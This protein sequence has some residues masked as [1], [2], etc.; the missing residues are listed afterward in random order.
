[1]SPLFFPKEMVVVRGREGMTGG[2]FRLNGTVLD[3][4]GPPMIEQDYN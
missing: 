3:G 1:M 4:R 2:S